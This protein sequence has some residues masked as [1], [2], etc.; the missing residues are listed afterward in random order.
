[1]SIVA[2]VLAILGA[3]MVPTCCCFGALPGGAILSAPAE[4]LAALLAWRALRQ[5][6]AVGRSARLAVWALVVAGVTLLAELTA[7]YLATEWLSPAMQ[8]T[9][10]STEAVYLLMHYAFETLGY[11]RFEWKCNNDNAPSRSAAA[12]FG[13]TFEGVFRQHM[14]VKGR[15]RDTAWFSIIDSEW[16]QRKQAFEAWLTPDNFDENGRQLS[17]LSALNAV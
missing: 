13:F 15:N 17:R 9:P 2:M 3:V 11:R 16:P 6:R 8:R 4:L 12:R 10:C 7:G 14:I 5:R 1:M